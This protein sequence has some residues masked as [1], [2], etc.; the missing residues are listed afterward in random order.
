[1]SRDPMA[2]T[3]WLDSEI[4]VAGEDGKIISLH[5]QRVTDT[6]PLGRNKFWHGRGPSLLKAGIWLS[7]ALK[8]ND[9]GRWDRR[10]DSV[11]TATAQLDNQPVVVQ[12]SF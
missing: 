7:E 12:V 2:N 6:L 10:S 5:S 4:K 1:M 3:K 8:V 11:F 9:I